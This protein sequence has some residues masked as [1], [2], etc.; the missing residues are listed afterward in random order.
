MR[1]LPRIARRLRVAARVVL[2]LM[3]VVVVAAMAVATVPNVLGYRTL[4]VTGGSMGASLPLGSVAITE[5]TP[6]D[7]IGIGDIIVARRD[8][9]DNGEPIAHRVTEI[10]QESGRTVFWTKGDANSSQDPTGVLLGPSG[11]ALVVKGHVPYVGYIVHFVQAPIGWALFV[12]A[13]AGLISLAALRGIWRLPMHGERPRPRA[14]G[15]L[16]WVF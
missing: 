5:G 3:M 13:P 2:G 8:D 9:G 11:E 1:I 6:G 4:A 15:W 7:E 16:R 12:L 14:T 10:G